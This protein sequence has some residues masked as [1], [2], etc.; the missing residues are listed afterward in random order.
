M[1]ENSGES[2]SVSVIIPAWNCEKS[3]ERCINSVLAQTHDKLQIIVSYD[4]SPDNTLSLLKNYSG[5]IEIIV[6]ENKSNPA[7]ARNIALNYAKGNYIAFLDSDDWW[8]PDKIKIQLEFMNSNPKIGLSYTQ[9]YIHHNSLTAESIHSV[10]YNRKKLQRFCFITHSSILVRKDILDEILSR[11]GYIFDENLKGADD[12]D[13]L[14]R[15]QKK[16]DMEL[17]P[18]PLTHSCLHDLNLTWNSKDVK[19][20]DAKVFIKNGL[21]LSLLLSFLP[22]KFV[23][24]KKRLFH[25]EWI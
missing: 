25:R 4:P 16:Y 23:D 7:I 9:S 13:L 3:I 12:Y 21:Y 2:M 19:I 22:Q 17:I 6:N 18:Q 8:E 1:F 11:E 24:F 20:Q 10:G 5:K 14:L 15:I